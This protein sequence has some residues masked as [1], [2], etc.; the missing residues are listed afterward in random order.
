MSYARVNRFLILIATGLAALPAGARA[1]MP[2][3]PVLQNSWA[4]PGMVVALDIAGGGGTLY[5]GAVGWAPSSGRFQLSA[6]AG[7]HSPK[8]GS[9]RAAYGVRAAFPVM[10]MMGGKLGFGGFVGIGGGGATSG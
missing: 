8:G 10:Q 4:S 7:S 5:G 9:S 1:Q 6:G 3:A 2:G